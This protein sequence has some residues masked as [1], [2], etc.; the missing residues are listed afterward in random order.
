MICGDPALAVLVAHVAD[1]LVA[2]VLAEVDVEVRHR[3]ALGVEEALEQQAEAQ[4]VEVG[5]R[6]RPGD[7]RA[8]ARAAARPDRD[9][10]RLGPLDEVG[11]DQEVAG[12]PH[13]GDHVELVGRA[14]RGRPLHRPRG[15]DHRREPRLEA[16]LGLAAQFLVLA[17]AVGGREGRQDRRAARH[18]E[19]A[20]PRDH[21]RVGDR[22][23]QVGEQLGHLGRRLEAVLGRQAAAVLLRDLGAVGDAEQHVVGLELVG[24]DEMHV[25]G[26]DQRQV[27]ASASSTS[28]GSIASSAAARGAS[29]R[30][31]GGPGSTPRDA[32][33]GPRRARGCP[34]AAP[35]RSGPRGRRSARSGRRRGRRGRRPRARARRRPRRRDRRGSRASGGSGSPA[36][37]AP[38]PAAA[39]A[40]PAGRWRRPGRRRAAAA[41]R[42]SAAGRRP[43]RRIGWRAAL[44]QV[45][46]VGDADRRHRVA[47]AALEQRLEPHRALEQRER[48]ADAQMDEGGVAQVRFLWLAVAAS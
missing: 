43:W 3:H 4:R 2:A 19:A 23:G 31:R 45:G 21:Q 24:L 37:P 42:R 36:R 35:C 9:A 16:G 27:A 14:A 39:P 22:L 13:A 28:A 40:A 26:R 20:A 7:H 46:A 5:D 32:R 1:H 12:E 10:A 6:E 44:E 11:D 41:A 48:G 34:A 25:V 47:P 17:A 33:A 8:G 18:H 15:C 30:R 38:G 29:A